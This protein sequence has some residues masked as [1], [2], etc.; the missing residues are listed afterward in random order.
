LYLSKEKT[1]T[2]ISNVYVVV[3]CC[4]QWV[5]VRGDC[6]FCL[7]WWNCL[8]FLF[9]KVKRRKNNHWS[10]KHSTEN[11]ILSNTNPTKTEITSGAAESKHLLFRY[12]T[13]QTSTKCQDWDCVLQI[14]LYIIHWWYQSCLN[15]S[16]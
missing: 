6:S 1:Y 9:R 7:Y 12:R 10:T 14:W 4:A 15:V 16:P 13:I 11:W 5:K 3:F 8:T 2:Y